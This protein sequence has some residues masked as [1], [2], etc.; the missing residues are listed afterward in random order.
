M[1]K[2]TPTRLVLHECGCLVDYVTDRH[3]EYPL[4]VEGCSLNE[5][6]TERLLAGEISDHAYLVAIKGHRGQ[7]V[8]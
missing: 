4:S 8:R 5:Q 1:I 6:V 7:V 2:S 3:G